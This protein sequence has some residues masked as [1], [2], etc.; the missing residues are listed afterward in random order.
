MFRPSPQPS[1]LPSIACLA[2][3]GLA[4]PLSG[5]AGT[6]E[7]QGIAAPQ[8]DAERR[9]VIA[10]PQ[11]T[12]AGE[13]HPIAF[14]GIL[15]SGDQA[16]GG[17]FGLLRD[18]AGAPLAGKD[19]APRISNAN[20]FSSLLPVGDRLFMVSHFE[21]RPGAM[22]LTELN[23][24]R[25]TGLLSPLA[26]RHIDFSGLGGVWNPCAG[27][28]T[29]WGSHLG[30]EEYEPDARQRDPATWQI[31]ANFA[32]MA[33]YY[34]GDVARLNPY[35]YGWPVEVKV[36]AAGGTRV[37]KRYA[38]GRVALELAYVMPDRRTAYL[39]D[40]GI[41]VGLYLFLADRPD[42]LS[43]GTLYAARWDQRPEPEG[44]AAG[45]AADLAWV[46]LG[47]ATEGE[48]ARA[49]ADKVA[50]PALFATSSL[51]A[52]ASQDASPSLGVAGHQDG[53]CPAGFTSVNTGHAKPKAECLKVQPGREAVA[54]RLETRRFAALRGAT[55]EWRKMEGLTFDPDGGRLYL[56]MTEIGGGMEDFKSKGKPDPAFDTGG[57]NDIRLPYNLCGTVYGM[58]VT[59]GV[60]DTDGNPIDSPFV[61]LDM[62][63]EVVGRMAGAEAPKEGNRCD[64]DGIANP[65]NL[66][67]IPGQRTLIIGEDTTEGHRNDAVWAYELDTKALRRILTTPYGSETTSVYFYPNINGFGYLMSVVQHP[68]GESDQDLLVKGSG[69]ERAYTGYLGP[70]PA[71]GK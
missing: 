36:D 27:S 34:G 24:D 20:D 40:D 63:G 42:D 10:S 57:R 29:P 15:R 17:T 31:D 68:Y 7:F 38:M 22:Y 45:G 48:V 54:S 30:S 53:V 4:L 49:I 37:A 2:L 21:E 67:F 61:A 12:I 35:A 56:A 16:G 64:I 13:A 32:A 59:A 70:F 6:L 3:A 58:N 25:A 44:S 39:T 9:Q 19:G 46:N 50:F 8:T 23:Q 66:T 69:E 71:L 51:P 60:K 18:H 26:T 65:D 28:V 55:T 33:A 43:A 1:R 47:H 41:N 14:H 5:T 62:I 11:V 52:P